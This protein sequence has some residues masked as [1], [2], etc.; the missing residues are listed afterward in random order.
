MN[1]QKKKKKVSVFYQLFYDILILYYA[2][3]G[4]RETIHEQIKD[5]DVQSLTEKQYLVDR[6]AKYVI[7]SKAENTNRKYYQHFKRFKSFCATRGYCVKPASSI[8]VSIYLTHLLDSGVSYNV[9]SASLYSIKWVHSISGLTDPTTNS[10]VRSLM[11]AGKRLRSAPV[12]K[13]DTINSDM[14]KQLCDMYRDSDDILHVR[15]ITMIVLAYAGFLRFSELSHLR[16][17]DIEFKSDYVLLK[18]RRSKTDVYRAGKEVI[19]AKGSST[20]CPYILLQKYLKLTC[21]N[22]TSNKYLFRPVNRSKGRASLLSQDKQLSY[23]RARECIIEKLKIVAP[24]LNLGTHSLR[25]SGA[26]VVANADSD[27]LNERC[28]M[29]HGR[30]KSVISKNGY[31]DDSLEKRLNVTKKL[32]L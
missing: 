21:Q 18:I 23:T 1:C 14:L 30:W 6:M 10:L 20:A 7:S 29:R 27:G 32:K 28:L 4:L 31:I 26:T 24:N 8:H 19:I 17:N 25:A 5:G 22:N 11:E 9:L 2:G 12:K 3:I 16:C 13:K 15:D